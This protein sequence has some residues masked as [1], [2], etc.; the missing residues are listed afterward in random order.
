MEIDRS[1]ISQK[2]GENV[3]FWAQEIALCKVAF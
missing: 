1:R 2:I 3:N